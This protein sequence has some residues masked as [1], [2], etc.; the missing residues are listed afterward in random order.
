MSYHLI[1][2]QDKDHWVED[3]IPYKP[4]QFKDEDMPIRK[5]Q[6]LHRIGECQRTLDL[7]SQ[8]GEGA[9]IQHVLQ[10]STDLTKFKVR[11]RYIQNVP[12]AAEQY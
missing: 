5:E 11:V 7:L 4:M 9:N 3:W 10:S 12:S 8:L 6:L 2:E 1:R